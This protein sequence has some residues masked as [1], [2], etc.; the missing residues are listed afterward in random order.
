MKT[1]WAVLGD[2]EDNRGMLHHTVPT[3]TPQLSYCLISDIVIFFTFCHFV[4]V[5]NVKKLQFNNANVDIVS[6]TSKTAKIKK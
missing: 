2:S 3:P 1:I 6:Y 4:L 5:I